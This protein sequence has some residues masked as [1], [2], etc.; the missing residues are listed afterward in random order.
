MKKR[1]TQNKL[2]F[3]LIFTSH[4]PEEQKYRILSEFRIGKKHSEATLEKGLRAVR[5]QS[6]F[7]WVL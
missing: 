3:L 6:S 5:H 2:F 7:S 1:Q 4:Y